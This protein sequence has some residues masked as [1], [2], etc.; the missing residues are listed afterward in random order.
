MAKVSQGVC[1]AFCFQGMQGGL[2]N[3]L[4]CIKTFSETGFTENLKKLDVPTLIIHGDDNQVVP[5]GATA[6]RSTKLMRNATLK[7]Y[8]GAPHGLADKHYLE[9]R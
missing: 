1:E 3:E 9:N 2:K 6:I 8:T 5:I 4:D 7:I